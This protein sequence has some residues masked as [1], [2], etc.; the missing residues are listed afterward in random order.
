MEDR[1]LFVIDSLGPGG[2]E[3]SLVDSLPALDEA[4]LRPTI[5]CLRS[6]KEGFETEARQR[7]TDVRILTRS[8]RFGRILEL[9]QMI[10]ALRPGLVHTTLFESDV[11]GRIAAVGTGVSV[12]TSLV[13]T[14]YDPIR[15]DDPNLKRWKLE[16][17]RLIDGW[18]ARHL[19]KRFHAISEAAKEA[20]IEDLG[21]PPGPVTVIPRGRDFTQLGKARPEHRSRVRH[22]LALGSGDQVLINVGRQEYAKGQKHLLE[23]MH[24]L[25]SERPHLILLIVGREGNA[26]EELLGLVA[27]LRLESRVRF[28]GHR[29]DV[30]DLLAAADVFVFPS[31]YE[32]LGGAILEAMAR[33]LPIVASDIPAL[34]EAT[35]PN[36]ARLV[37]RGSATALAEA[38]DELLADPQEREAMSV[39]NLRRSRAFDLDTITKRMTEFYRESCGAGR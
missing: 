39:K 12:S 28:L 31:L 3:R 20:A 7:G 17:T 37:P 26:S 4:G 1:I 38:I 27:Q 9:R 6:A 19:S 10:R 35:D 15:L 16:I 36:G 11:I 22:Q 30:G 29:S 8:S 25:V 24:L 33:G 18:T 13:S 21:I 14:P 34:R 32:G 2:A 23:A 5:A